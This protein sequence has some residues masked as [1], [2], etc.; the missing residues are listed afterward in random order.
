MPTGNSNYNAL[1]AATVEYWANG[2]FANAVFDGVP[3][4]KW[5]RSGGREKVYDG[6][7]LILEPVMFD[8]NGTIQSQT[9]FQ[10]VNNTP[11]D[12]MTDAQFTPAMYTGT[13]VMS[14]LDQAQNSGTAKMIDVW[15]AKVEQMKLAFQVQLNTDSFL[16]GTQAPY[17][18][19]GLAAIVGSTGTYGN[20]SRTNNTFWQSYVEA[21]AGVLSED[22]IR[23][24]Y[25]TVGRLNTYPDAMWTTQTLYQKYESLIVPALR[26]TPGDKGDLGVPSLSYHG[27]PIYYDNQCQSGVFYFLTSQYLKFRPLKGWNMEITDRRQ[28]TRQ[29]VDMV[30]AYFAG[31][32]TC[33]NCRYQGKLTGRTAA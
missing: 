5:L 24:G 28:P 26:F 15:E 3:F 20:I 23:T 21:T 12:G 33:S 10:E 30:I 32:I 31:Q 11:Q 29:L 18:L 8:T 1:Q 2:K 14:W 17:A 16:D 4:I 6:G 13:A 25:Y 7:K 27:T 19:T 22:D 9:P